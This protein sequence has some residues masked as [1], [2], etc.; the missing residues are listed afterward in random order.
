MC[1]AKDCQSKPIAK[2][3][4]DKHYRKMKK[5]GDPNF[6]ANESH[7]MKKTKVYRTWCHM[8]GRCHNENDKAYVYYGARGILVCDEWRKSFLSFFN[9]IGDPPSP[10]HQID[11]IDNSKGYEP[12]NVRW[13]LSSTNNQ[14]RRSTKVDSCDIGLIR[15]TDMPIKVIVK[16][17]GISESQAYRI[18]KITRWVDIGTPSFDYQGDWTNSLRKRPGGK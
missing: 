13:V 8:K 15:S 10:K 17:Y 7:G 16:T 4:C 6:S 2:G 11:R 1:E 14:N 12:N 5:Y 18:K 9:H 3:L